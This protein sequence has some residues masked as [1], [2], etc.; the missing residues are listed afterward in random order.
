M[1]PFPD[2]PRND[3]VQELLDVQRGD[4]LALAVPRGLRAVLRVEPGDVRLYALGGSEV[5]LSAALRRRIAA[6]LSGFPVGS[7]LDVVT[8]DSRIGVF[9]CDCLRFGSL[10]LGAERAIDRFARI[11]PFAPVGR[12]VYLPDLSMGDLR[13]FL[14][15]ARADPAVAAIVVKRWNSG[16]V[17]GLDGPK[18]NQD[19]FRVRL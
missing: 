15:E 5:T 12:G 3:A 6:V 16:L 13:E 14:E 17:G 9:L 18:V 11:A 10:W 19:W 1:L 7:A 2:V 4:W 8:A